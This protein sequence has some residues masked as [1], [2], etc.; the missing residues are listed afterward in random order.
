M[1]KHTAFQTCCN[2]T[3]LLVVFLLLASSVPIKR[4]FGQEPKRPALQ[5]HLEAAGSDSNVMLSVR[6]VSP[7]T[8][9][10]Y[11]DMYSKKGL[12]GH[13]LFTIKD[14]KGVVPTSTPIGLSA[15]YIHKIRYLHPGCVI[16][17]DLTP[18]QTQSIYFN[19]GKLYNLSAGHYRVAV[20]YDPALHDP[21]LP[22]GIHP[23]NMLKT[24][25][26]YPSNVIDLTVKSNSKQ[27]ALSLIVHSGD[28]A[29]PYH[30]YWPSVE[31]KPTVLSYIFPW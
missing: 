3:R 12:V 1:R 19:L 8:Q 23:P 11:W 4:G 25:S 9:S 28:M 16:S 21:D 31:R 22:D 10:I 20:R 15:Y 5:L 7:Q 30:E 14:T 6:N 27:P 29:S 17:S 13:F 2:D 24:S 26:I 18:D